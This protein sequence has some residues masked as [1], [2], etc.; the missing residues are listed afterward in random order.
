MYLLLWT[1]ISS[2][3][4]RLE[5]LLHFPV[6]REERLLPFRRG[7]LARGLGLWDL[8]GIRA[9]RPARAAAGRVFGLEKPGLRSVVWMDR[10]AL[11]AHEMLKNPVLTKHVFAFDLCAICWLFFL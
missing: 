11:Q 3:T 5:R 8:C 4:K 1:S 10:R 9:L 6:A 2:W 7:E